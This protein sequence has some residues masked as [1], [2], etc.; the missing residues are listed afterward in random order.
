MTLSRKETKH[1]RTE[2]IHI[3][4][5]DIFIKKSVIQIKFASFFK[6]IAKTL[7]YSKEMSHNI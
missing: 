2:R 5:D 6:K 3:L 7:D 4:K 1:V